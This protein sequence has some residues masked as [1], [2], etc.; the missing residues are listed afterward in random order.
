MKK[1][2]TETIYIEKHS[3]TN[4]VLVYADELNI[5]KIFVSMSILDYFDWFKK[6]T[7]WTKSNFGI[8]LNPKL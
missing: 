7:G 5:L 3:E 1:N 4:L 2:R 8:D 6:K